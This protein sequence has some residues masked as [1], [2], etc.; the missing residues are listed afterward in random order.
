MDPY[1]LI[2]SLSILVIVSY[3]F[4]L[5]AKHFKIPSVLLLMAA[6]VAIASF[7]DRLGVVLPTLFTPLN[8][9]GIIGLM[10]IVLEGA[11]DIKMGRSQLKTLA[12][13][14]GSALLILMT[15]TILIAALFKFAFET[16]SF[17][18]FLYS[19]PLSVVSSA[20]VIPSV[21][22]LITEKKDFMV[23]E[24]TFSDILG[25]MLFDFLIFEPGEGQEY[26]SSIGLNILISIVVSLILSYLLVFF[27]HK[28]T[29]RIKLFLFLSILAMLFAIGKYLHYSSLI[30]VLI[31]GLILNNSKFF[32]KNFMSK[33]INHYEIGYIRDEF[34]Q[35]TEESSFLIRTFFFIV[36]GMSLQINDLADLRVILLGSFIMIILYLIRGLNL[37]LFMKT[38]IMPEVLIAP[39]GLVT[40]LLFYRIPEK[41]AIPQ[42]QEAILVYVIAGTSILMM[43]G[44]V[45]SGFS[46]EDTQRQA[47]IDQEENSSKQEELT[48][49]KVD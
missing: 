15:T 27:F 38:S 4:T 8:L 36:F 21:N 2:I 17:Q 25:I 43:I 33:Y 32:F 35:I 12:R 19:V 37:K 16:T 39:R 23:S 24:S 48:G 3:G 30:I 45:L 6:G 44:L 20:I 40:I 47:L 26:W 18:A 46:E 5:I 10:M 42:F 1:L 34:R 41:Y 29:S 13:S 49:S 28:I 31:F 14:F 11:L 22:S 7:T 9:L